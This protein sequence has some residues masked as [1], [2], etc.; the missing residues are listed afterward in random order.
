MVRLFMSVR[1]RR[2]VLAQVAPRY[3]EAAGKQRSHILDEFVATT[4]YARKYAIRLCSSP[5]HAPAPIQRSRLP[6]YGP[7]VRAALT[8][9]WSAANG[10]CAKRLVPFLPELVP[11]LEH[12]GHL[13]LDTET[14]ALLLRLSAATADRLLR[15]V[16]Q[17]DTPRGIS[18]TK[19]GGLLKQQIPIRTFA[20]WDDLRPGFLEADLVAHCG[21]NA[22]GAYLYTLTLTDVSTGW[23]EC[24]P[25]LHRGQ[26]AVI[27]AVTHA[28]RLLPV[29][30][31][32]LDT[33]NGGEFI[34]A[35]M[36]AYC[37]SEQITFTR[38]R[39]ARSNDQCF[40]EQKN[41]SIVRQLVGYDRFTGE[42]AYRQ[43]AELYRAVRLYVNFFQPSVKL[44]TKERIGSQVRRHYDL[45]QTPY[46]R[47]LAANVLD[48]PTQ[49]WLSQLAKALDPVLLL[50]QLQT[51]QDALWR[52]ATLPPAAAARNT[53]PLY[54]VRFDVHACGTTAATEADGEVH[55]SAPAA[56][57]VEQPRRRYRRTPKS[58]GPR[59]Y[60]TRPDPF[61]AVWD[62]IRRWLEA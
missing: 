19:P 47:L 30:I 12:H 31:R 59:A 11:A 42:A 53:E 15:S 9:A 4:G 50:R 46:Q 25:L 45:A 57:F 49:A 5:V 38:G 61:L 52:H 3:Q 2:E 54:E 6:C 22:E 26:D 62:E 20:A 39:V 41:G 21:G 34:N 51:L 43:L 10:I 33:D 28:R 40:V 60:R 32:G 23:T 8:V 27:Q 13:H 55:T 29:P 56:N 24:L 37:A 7:A 36:L 18:T 58:L 44:Q 48:G 35:A 14:R 1:A 17:I 16:R